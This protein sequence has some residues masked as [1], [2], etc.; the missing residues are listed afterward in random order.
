MTLFT[1]D[2]RYYL[3]WFYHESLEPLAMVGSKARRFTRGR[4]LGGRSLLVNDLPDLQTRE[5]LSCTK[6]E[7]EKEPISGKIPA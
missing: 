7:F 4:L 2:K 3:L 5:K 6:S 1:G